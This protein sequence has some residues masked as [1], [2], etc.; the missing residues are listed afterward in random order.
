MNFTQDD[1]DLIKK[2]IDKANVNIPIDVRI[3][4]YKYE[5]LQK[6]KDQLLQTPDVVGHTVYFNKERGKIVEIEKDKICLLMDSGK[7]I[8]FED[9]EVDRIFT[10][11]NP[12]FES[13]ELLFPSSKSDNFSKALNLI[14]NESSF[15]VAQETFNKKTHFT[16]PITLDNIHHF[17][18]LL[19]LVYR[20][21]NV[22]LR[23]NSFSISGYH[24]R[25]IFDCFNE[26]LD[27]YKENYCFENHLT[28]YPSEKPYK[29]PFGCVYLLD[30]NPF[31]GWYTKG[32][33]VN[34]YQYEIDKV[35]IEKTINDHCSVCPIYDKNRALAK[36]KELPQL[37][38]LRTNLDWSKM[39]FIDSNYNCNT[40]II[41]VY[42]KQSLFNNE[43]F[44]APAQEFTL[45]E[46]KKA[47]VTK[48]QLAN[49]EFRAPRDVF[50][51]H[52]KS[53]ECCHNCKQDN[54][55]YEA[56]E[57]MER[58][59][60]ERKLPVP[61]QNC[62]NENCRCF[63]LHFS[64]KY[65]FID[66]NGQIK[67][68]SE[69]EKEWKSWIKNRGLQLEP[70]ISY[71]PS[72]NEEEKGRIHNLK[73]LFTIDGRTIGEEYFNKEILINHG[74]KY[75]KELETVLKSWSFS[76]DPIN[77]EYNEIIAKFSKE[78]LDRIAFNKS[79]QLYVLLLQRYKYCRGRNLSSS[80]LFGFYLNENENG[81]LH[82]VLLNNF[83]EL[84]SFD[85]M[86]MF[87]PELGVFEN[88][89]QM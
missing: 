47:I 42:I 68:K 15:R 10:V 51:F 75:F 26:L 66:E 80:G 8:I 85:R 7:T 54:A 25:G 9:K 58:W 4:Y 30:D 81:K 18:S 73:I 49:F 32:K 84:N 74:Q 34:D 64:P 56:N 23:N 57:L 38:D 12:N 6:S 44:Y 62:E 89:I 13:T 5:S 35:E 77:N 55:V 69:N 52:H 17:Q 61:T 67:L 78:E 1:Y 71:L 33:F 39:E 24:S 22:E 19:D 31:C 72:L 70:P 2:Y 50:F 11:T 65:Q 82:F 87:D 36:L 60:N 43:S 88:D 63:L 41:P 3:E 21:N 46:I 37:L 29:N 14:E 27:N 83:V 59:Q 45:K 40:K 76:S 48:K 28:I 79:L 86:S 16:V 53:N 20:F